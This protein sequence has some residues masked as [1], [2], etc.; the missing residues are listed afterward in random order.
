MDDKSNSDTNNNEAL[1]LA[2]HDVSAG[3]AP[4]TSGVVQL[5]KD[6]NALAENSGH[7]NA[8]PRPCSDDGAPKLSRRSPAE[9]ESVLPPDENTE[10]AD[11]N[12]KS[13]SGRARIS[14]CNLCG[15]K[16]LKASELKRHLVYHLGRKP[17]KC[18][19]SN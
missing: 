18:N 12:Q 17:F 15:K 9:D 10:A 19:V 16:C 8:S 3:P 5:L 13:S 6:V 1:R 14:R 11:R 4:S 7:G 2:N